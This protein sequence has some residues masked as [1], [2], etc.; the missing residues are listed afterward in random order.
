MVAPKVWPDIAAVVDISACNVRADT[1]DVTGGSN[2]ATGGK[3]QRQVIAAEGAVN[4]RLITVGRVIVATGVRSERRHA[5]SRIEAAINIV[6]KSYTTSGCV[7][8]VGGRVI[9]RERSISR[10]A[11]AVVRMDKERS[12]A[13]GRVEAGLHIEPK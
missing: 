7:G 1:D 4:E 3:T 13:S 9:Q 5:V 6:E 12:G 10:V 2:S 8:L 11:I